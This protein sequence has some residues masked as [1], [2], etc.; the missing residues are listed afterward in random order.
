MASPCRSSTAVFRLS[1][2]RVR[3]Q[4]PKAVMASTCPRRKLSIVWS[5]VKST[6]MAR[7]QLK[8]ITKAE[9]GRLALPTCTWPK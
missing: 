8:T 5:R 3:A 1:Y 2:R 6:W 9:N 7:D 4:P